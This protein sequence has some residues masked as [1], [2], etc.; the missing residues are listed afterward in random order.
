MSSNQNNSGQ[1]GMPELDIEWEA[2]QVGDALPPPAP[3]AKAAAPV[4]S[5]DDLEEVELEP[6]ELEMVELDA[7]PAAAPARVA[8]AAAGVTCNHCGHVHATD[9]KFCDAC[10]LRIDKIG[11]LKGLDEDPAPVI[12]EDADKVV[13]GDCGV[14]NN[15]G[16]L[17]CK[18]CGSK[19][20]GNELI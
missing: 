6:D 11:A 15:A 8:T 3:S 12:D 1:D 13:C 20:R 4:H 18:N 16:T 17:L 7:E 2:P 9:T 14:R 5:G 10:G 19:L